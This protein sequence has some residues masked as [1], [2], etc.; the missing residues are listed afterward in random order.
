TTVWGI[1]TK[2]PLCP[3]WLVPIILASYYTGMRLNEVLMIQ[4]HQIH[5]HR[6][7]MYLTPVD[8]PI[9]EREPKRIPIHR[10]LEP[11]LEESLKVRASGIDNVFLLSDR[12]GTRPVTK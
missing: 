2:R 12:Q 3:E 4:R 5:L 7:M 8:Q 9:K 6:R 1:N 11:V 10:D